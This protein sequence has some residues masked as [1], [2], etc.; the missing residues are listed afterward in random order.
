MSLPKLQV[1]GVGTG[2][3]NICFFRNCHFIYL[4][5]TLHANPERFFHITKKRFHHLTVTIEHRI[6]NGI[7]SDLAGHQIQFRPHWVFQHSEVRT[8]RPHRQKMCIRRSVFTRH[9]GLNNLGSAGITRNVMRDDAADTD[10]E[11]SFIHVFIDQNPPPVIRETEIHK[12][13]FILVWVIFDP[14]TSNRFL[15]EFLHNLVIRHE[16]MCS[17]RYDERDLFVGHPG[18][19]AFIQQN[20]NQLIRRRQSRI[21]I[22]HEYHVLFAPHQL[23]KRGRSNRMSQRPSYFYFYVR[24]RRNVFG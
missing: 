11:I 17:Q 7:Q 14:N 4:R 9:P 20:G 22:S 24:Y 19:I 1:T 3:D 16:A 12:L 21:I 10:L 15:A 6:Q 13:G 5:S 18:L 23:L 2:H 8:R